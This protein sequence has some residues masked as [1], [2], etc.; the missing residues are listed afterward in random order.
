MDGWKERIGDTAEQS[1]QAQFQLAQ[2]RRT[3]Q[4]H[5]AETQEAQEKLPPEPPLDAVALTQRQDALRAL[6]GG[7]WK[8]V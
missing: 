5:Q 4:D 8:R 7:G 2:E 6:R 3:L 1:Q